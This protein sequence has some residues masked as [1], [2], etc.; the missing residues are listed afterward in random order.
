MKLIKKI[1]HIVL[2]LE[3]CISIVVLVVSALACIVIMFYPLQ[4]VDIINSLGAS[5]IDILKRI[6]IV[7]F[8]LLCFWLLTECFVDI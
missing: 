1:M 3:A 7:E 6:A 4:F 5:E 8:C 2:E